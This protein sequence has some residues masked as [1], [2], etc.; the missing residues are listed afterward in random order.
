MGK[1]KVWRGYLLQGRFSSCPMDERYLVAAAAYVEL[2]PVRA[3][4][5]EMPWNYRRNSIHAHL[6]GKS[7]GIVNSIN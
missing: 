5:V 3:G 7:V 4:K 6:A 1:A 2:Y